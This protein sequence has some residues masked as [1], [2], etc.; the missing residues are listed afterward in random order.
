MILGRLHTFS[1]GAVR[2][3]PILPLVL[4]LACATGGGARPASPP[5]P[6]F[7][8]ADLNAIDPIQCPCGL[9]KRAFAGAPDT[10]ASVHVVDIQLDAK[11]HYHKV[12]T[13][14]YVVLEGEGKMELDGQLI[15]VKPMNVI[16]IKPGCRHRA[17]G[18]I[19]IL[20]IPIPPF[21]PQDEWFD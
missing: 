16:Y 7:L 3:L 2:A 13:E 6:R 17:V 12:M 9:A 10:L 8:V 21:D 15:P 4:A 19:K 11:T 20:N 18:R 1:R 14:I 5:A